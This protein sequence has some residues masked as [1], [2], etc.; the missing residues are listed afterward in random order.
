LIILFIVFK[1]YDI[2]NGFLGLGRDLYFLILANIK[3][4]VTF[5]IVCI[6]FLIFSFFSYVAF[7]KKHIIVNLIEVFF[8]QQKKVLS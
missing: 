3:E 6:Y 1:A 2:K 4:L 5:Q 7:A 8:G